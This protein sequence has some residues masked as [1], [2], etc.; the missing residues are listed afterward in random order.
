MNFFLGNG[1]FFCFFGCFVETWSSLKIH[2]VFASSSL[3]LHYNSKVPQD[4]SNRKIFF[5]IFK[6]QILV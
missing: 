2:F 6:G 5:L 1:C 4:A 3:L